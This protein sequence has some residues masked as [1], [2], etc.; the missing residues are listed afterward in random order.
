[1][2]FAA[3]SPAELKTIGS[4]SDV[5]ACANTKVSYNEKGLSIQDFQVA[6]SGLM[7]D[8]MYSDRTYNQKGP[9]GTS[10]DPTSDAVHTEYYHGVDIKFNHALSSIVFKVAAAEM[11][12][13]TAA[14]IDANTTITLNS[15]SVN[16][17]IYQGHFAENVDETTPTA[18]KSSPEWDLTNSTSARTDYYLVTNVADVNQKLTNNASAVNAANALMFIPQDFGKVDDDNRIS[19]TVNYTITNPDGKTWPQTQTVFLSDFIYQ[20]EGYDNEKQPA[21]WEMGKRYTYTITI[22]LSQIHLAPEVAN[23][24]YVTAEQVI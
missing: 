13:G 19:V 23:W 11:T 3:Y 17:V 2:T 16:N 6:P 18:Y 14:E 9:H 15:I 22:G 4:N 24:I 5:L 12:S 21:G 1:M 10:Y 20:G 8:L 7:Y